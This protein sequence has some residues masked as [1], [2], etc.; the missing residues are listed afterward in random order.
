[1]RQFQLSVRAHWLFVFVTGLRW[2]R[3]GDFRM[4]ST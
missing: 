2:L 3:V 1:L 4:R